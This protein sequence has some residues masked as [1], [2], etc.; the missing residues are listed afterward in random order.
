MHLS[1]PLPSNQGGLE[2]GAGQGMRHKA[3][4]FKKECWAADGKIKYLRRWMGWRIM[5]RETLSIVPWKSL[6]S[7]SIKLPHTGLIT[8]LMELAIQVLQNAVLAVV[9][10]SSEVP[11]WLWGTATKNQTLQKSLLTCLYKYIDCGFLKPFFKQYRTKIN[12]KW[13]LYALQENPGNTNL[14]TACVMKQ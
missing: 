3:G 13:L 8:F 7:C 5:G 12:I 4:G 2:D 1:L 11:L 6:H 10:G 14:K 9:Q